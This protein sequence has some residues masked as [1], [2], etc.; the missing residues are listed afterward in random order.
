MIM[1]FLYTVD[2][3]DLERFGTLETK[4]LGRVYAVV[5]GTLLLFDN[6]EEAREW[7]EDGESPP[8]LCGTGLLDLNHR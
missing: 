6:A 7:Y 8:D 4:D 2:E 3:E 5:C 1:P